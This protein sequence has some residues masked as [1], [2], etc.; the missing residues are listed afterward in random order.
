V[1][2]S[3]AASGV[4]RR[5]FSR[6][7]TLRQG[8]WRPKRLTSNPMALEPRACWAT[9]CRLRRLFGGA[10]STP[11]RLTAVPTT[12]V[13]GLALMGTCSRANLFLITWTTP[14]R[15]MGM[16]SP[17]CCAEQRRPPSEGRW[18]FQ[19]GADQP[20]L[21]P[22][23]RTVDSGVVLSDCLVDSDDSQIKRFAVAAL[24]R[25]I[26]KNDKSDHLV[27]GNLAPSC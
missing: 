18:D 24:Y 27:L 4:V 10:P 15:F 8:A 1:P 17:R 22:Y 21:C 7:R 2:T 25:M 3:A 19:Q 9:P 23:A 14:K 5:S 13:M 16:P 26:S 20:L 6:N 12:A 11:L